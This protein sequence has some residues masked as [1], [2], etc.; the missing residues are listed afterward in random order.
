ML[1]VLSLAQDEEAKPLESYGRMHY[2]MSTL[3]P[4]YTWEAHEVV[5][6]DGFTLTTFHFTGNKSGAYKPDKPPVFFQHGAYDDAAGWVGSDYSGEL[7]VMLQLAD[8][9]FDV[10]MGNNRGTEYSQQHLEYTVD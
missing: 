10:W 1:A 9:G 7:P 8:S 3:Y 4:D 6:D 2:A 5:T